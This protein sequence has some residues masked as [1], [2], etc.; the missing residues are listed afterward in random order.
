MD[1]DSQFVTISY[2]YIIYEAMKI[3]H[4]FDHTDTCLHCGIHRR[5]TSSPVLEYSSDGITF[6]K[7]FINCKEKPSNV[8]TGRVD[9]RDPKTLHKWEKINGSQSRCKYCKC[10][11]T[12]TH[13]TGVNTLVYQDDRG[14]IHKEYIECIGKP[15]NSEFYT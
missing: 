12:L 8:S 11:R 2:V 10:I 14:I 3:Y 9:G 5:R 13:H 7:E 15:D 1:I 6:S 4:R